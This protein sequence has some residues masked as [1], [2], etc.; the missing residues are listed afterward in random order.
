MDMMG[1][2]KSIKAHFDT[3]V[4]SHFTDETLELMNGARENSKSAK[5]C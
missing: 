2:Y 5:S 1:F 4:M 3:Y